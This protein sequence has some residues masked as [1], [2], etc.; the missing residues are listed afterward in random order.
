MEVSKQYIIDKGGFKK[1]LP[2]VIDIM[3]KSVPP[4]VP[5]NLA[6]AIVLSEVSAFVSSWRNNIL[7]NSPSK[8]LKTL[9]PTNT[10]IFSLV[11]KG[12]IS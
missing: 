7:M 1:E 10:Y 5:R 8:K 11:V 12:N 9:V 4:E 6:L 3:V 2:Y